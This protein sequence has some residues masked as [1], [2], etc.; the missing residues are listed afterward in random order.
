MEP[1][2]RGKV[3][4]KKRTGWPEKETGAGLS[5]KWLQTSLWAYP[6]SCWSDKAADRMFRSREALAKKRTGRSEKEKG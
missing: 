4:G 5:E 3:P 6:G 1:F 2:D